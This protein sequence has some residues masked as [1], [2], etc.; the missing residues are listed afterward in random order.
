M[1]WSI[2]LYCA[3]ATLSQAYVLKSLASCSV[4]NK[5][6]MYFSL[7]PA[8]NHYM[9]KFG[10]PSQ[11]DSSTGLFT[12]EPVFDIFLNKSL[13]FRPQINDSIP[14]LPLNPPDTLLKLF[15]SFNN[16]PP[17]NPNSPFFP[18]VRHTSDVNPT[19]G[20]FLTSTIAHVVYLTTSCVV[21][22]IIAPQ[23]YLSFKHKKTKNFG[24][25]N[26]SPEATYLRS[27]VSF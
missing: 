23:I 13:S 26:D 24:Y 10:L 17:V 7:N 4:K 16:K 6:T 25:S 15:Q 18:L 3:T 22:C 11:N 14:L 12:Y 1:Y 21:V 2:D 8:F 20:S 5:F 9:H 27:N 19:K